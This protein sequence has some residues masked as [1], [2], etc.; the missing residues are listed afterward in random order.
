VTPAE[1]ALRY[2]EL[3]NASETEAAEALEHPDIRFWLSGRLV[4]SGDLRPEQHRKA[5]AG[6][7]AT[8]PGGYT[9]HVRSV[10]EQGGRVAVEAQG[11]GVL[12]DGTRYTPEY[13]IFFEVRDGLITSMREY[14]DTEYV[15]ATFGLA[16]REG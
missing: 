9:L 12:A 3:S 13:A 14:I 16:R 10:I 4:V 1:T 7:H 2:L 15:G 5:T 11:D 8:F 6:V